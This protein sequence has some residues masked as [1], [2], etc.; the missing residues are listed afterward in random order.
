METRIWQRLMDTVMGDYT[1][2]NVMAPGNGSEG[3]DPLAVNYADLGPLGLVLNEALDATVNRGAD[4]DELIAVIAQGAGDGISVDDVNAVLGGKQL[5]PE[6]ALLQ[7]F[8]TVFCID[9]DVILDAGTRG[10]CT[11]Y[12]APG[13]PPPGY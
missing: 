3:D 5:C 13:S 6:L 9:L 8:S 12:A 4:R 1:P 10:G 11:Q 7:A 2:G